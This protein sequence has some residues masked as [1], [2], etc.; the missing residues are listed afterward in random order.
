M[1]VDRLI[2]YKT[3][4]DNSYINTFDIEGNLGEEQPSYYYQRAIEVY[5]KKTVVL[6]SNRALKIVDNRA[7]IT[8]PEE[9]SF[10]RDYNYCNISGKWFFIVN[11]TSEN[12]NQLN[13]STTIDVEWDSWANNLDLIHTKKNSVI[14]Q[15]EQR[16]MNRYIKENYNI[17]PIY[18]RNNIEEIVT[19]QQDVTDTEV[20]WAKITLKSFPENFGIESTNLG[21]LNKSVTVTLPVEIENQA[22]LTITNVST[23]TTI[24]SKSFSFINNRYILYT[25]MAIIR[26][27]DIR[28]G[29]VSTRLQ[30][31]I[32]GDIPPNGEYINTIED[33]V[34]EFDTGEQLQQLPIFG[35]NLLYSFKG[36][37]TEYIETIEYTYF[38]PLEYEVSN[39]IIKITNDIAKTNLDIGVPTYLTI[40]DEIKLSINVKR[41]GPPEAIGDTVNDVTFKVTNI[42]RKFVT[43][44]TKEF[45]IDIGVS[46]PSTD[47]NSGGLISFIDPKLDIYPFKYYSICY[48]NE[49]YDIIPSRYREHLF[50][51]LVNHL[52]NQPMIKILASET[53]DYFDTIKNERMEFIDNNGSV[54]YATR[55]YDQYMINNGSQKR[56]SM[57][58]GTIKNVISTVGGI[59]KLGIGIATMNPS[60]IVSGSIGTTQGLM[61]TIG[62]PIM[63]GAKDTDLKRKPDTLNGADYGEDDLFYQDRLVVIENYSND[64]ILIDRY[65]HNLYLYG[66]DINM[67]NLVFTNN[68]YW[69]DYVRTNNLF[70]DLP[71]N[72]NDK[73]TIQNIYR[74]GTFRYHINVDNE[75]NIDFDNTLNKNGL[76]NNI[77]R[78]LVEVN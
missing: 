24:S 11:I 20:L 26:G 34:F 38:C 73:I 39:D 77:E 27:K 54:T 33:V 62:D 53:G 64:N 47:K 69:F 65:K 60:S 19:Q 58:L 21:L 40:D 30:G 76:R 23:N 57:A 7:T 63:Q 67:D 37:H 15:V 2:L 12:D 10:I 13:P 16:H 70:L 55:A 48:G 45:D 32:K 50:K 14:A 49:K 46:Q 6:P 72:N 66:Y 42:N 61:S 71:I 52:T 4:L 18:Y 41:G 25:P 43:E 59:S 3:P 35:E 75:G 22:T 74:R 44:H 56:S 28:N 29:Y 31:T 78:H 5:D 1:I 68:R 51:I 17:K 9:Y 8:I 36:V